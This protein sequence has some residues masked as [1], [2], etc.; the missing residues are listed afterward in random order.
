[1][2]AELIQRR[3]LE[4]LD[5]RLVCLGVQSW[6]DRRETRANSEIVGFIGRVALGGV[7]VVCWFWGWTRQGQVLNKSDQTAPPG[8]SV[9]GIGRWLDIFETT[10]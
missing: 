9:P 1:M 6:P 7:L 8:M 4:I 3:R 5:Y 10:A 2:F